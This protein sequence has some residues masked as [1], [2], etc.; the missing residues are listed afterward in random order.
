MARATRRSVAALR[1]ALANR[2]PHVHPQ[3]NL[4]HLIGVPGQDLWVAGKPAGEKWNITSTVKLTG[5]NLGNGRRPL[6]GLHL[7]AVRRAVPL[8]DVHHAGAASSCVGSAMCPPSNSR[9]A[10]AFLTVRVNGNSY[11]RNFHVD[12]EGGGGCN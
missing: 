1:Q 3:R 9:T 10:P 11:E 8:E 6:D 5:R 7:R 2:P 12:G 4:G